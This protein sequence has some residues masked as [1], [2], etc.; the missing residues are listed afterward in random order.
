MPHYVIDV[1]SPEEQAQLELPVELRS[2]IR[3]PGAGLARPGQAA[4]Q[5]LGKHGRS[6]SLPA[7]GPGLTTA[8][9]AAVSELRGALQKAQ[10]W[11]QHA[12]E[13]RPPPTP[14]HVLVLLAADVQAGRAAAFAA[15]GA[16]FP[17][18]VARLELE[19]ASDAAPARWGA[20]AAA[21]A[22]APAPAPASPAPAP[23]PAPAS[24]A[25][26]ASPAPLTSAT[27][28]PPLQGGH[29]GGRAAGVLQQQQQRRQR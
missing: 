2:A 19:R 1:R 25:S 14:G 21:P 17:R 18:W 20:A 24:P 15:A 27:P 16:G 9:P 11:F 26:P 6:P 23:A 5:S 3:I 13:E 10:E 22:P 7:P 8:T 4:A 12:G 28:T 29:V